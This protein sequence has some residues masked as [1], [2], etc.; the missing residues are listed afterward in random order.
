MLDEVSIASSH[1]DF[2]FGS[3]ILDPETCVLSF[4]AA[5]SAVDGVKTEFQPL[6]KL[7]HLIFRAF[8]KLVKSQLQ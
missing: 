1:D 6:S 8:Y 7:L 4:D 2:R 5:L 3:L